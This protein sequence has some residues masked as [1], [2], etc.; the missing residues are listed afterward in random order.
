M[1]R[2]IYHG[3]DHIVR[4]PVFGAGR[5]FNDFGLGFY[6]AEYPEYAAEWAVESDRNGFVSAYSIDPD[7]LRAINLCGPQYNV[8]HW[9]SLLLAFREFDMSS[10][11]A[12]RAREYINKYYSVDY[13]SC[14][15][16]TGYRADNRL[17]M[18][19]QEFLDGRLAYQDLKRLVSGNSNRQFVLKSNRAFDRVSFSGYRPALSEDSYPVR[20]SR[21]LRA[22]KSLK[23]SSGGLFITDLIEQ[24]VRPYDSRL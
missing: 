2:K 13:Q 14:D 1:E 22:I 6:C 16:I 11:T 9:L 18:F 23:Q 12:H 20:R 17:F 15:C 4:T 19:A 10:D 21:E 7:G 8:L 3:S 5:P 24:E